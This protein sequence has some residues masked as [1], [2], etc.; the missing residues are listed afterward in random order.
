MSVSTIRQNNYQNEISAQKRTKHTRHSNN[1]NTANLQ[2][3]TNNSTEESTKTQ[4]TSKR[5]EAEE[6]A[7]FKKEFYAEIERIPRDRTIANVAIHI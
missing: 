7:A 1:T 4:N 6:M 2:T 3:T 5:A